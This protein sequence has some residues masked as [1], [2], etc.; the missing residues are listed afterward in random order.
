MKD[1]R[2]F[3]FLGL[4]FFAG[5][6]LADDT[7]IPAPIT[8]TF[9][10]PIPDRAVHEKLLIHWLH[11]DLFAQSRGIVNTAIRDQV[12]KYMKSVREEW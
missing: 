9:Q 3:V 4:G 5:K 1:R 10:G 7:R 2:A 11:Q 6:L 8:Y 12:E